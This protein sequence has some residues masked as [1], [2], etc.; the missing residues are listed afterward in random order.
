MRRIVM[1]IG[2]AAAALASSSP[3]LASDFS[4]IGRLFWW[5]VLAFPVLIVLA[6]ALFRRRRQPGSRAADALLSCFAAVLLAPG[7]L[8]YVDDQWLPVLFPGLG[9]A[10]LEGEAGLLFPVPFLSMMLCWAGLFLLF[11]RLRARHMTDDGEG[12]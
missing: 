4:G 7:L 8:I 6:V 10:M 11:E 3:A 1:R 9:V 2:L 12:E 5:A